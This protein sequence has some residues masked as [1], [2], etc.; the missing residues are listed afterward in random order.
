MQSE[1]NSVERFHQKT[2]EFEVWNESFF[3]LL[4]FRKVILTYYPIK[5]AL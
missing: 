4:P 3:F 2:L 1:T 5:N